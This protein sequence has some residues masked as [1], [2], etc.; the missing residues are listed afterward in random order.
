MLTLISC[1]DAF[2]NHKAIDSLHISCVNE[3]L[4]NSAIPL[5]TS[6]FYQPEHRWVWVAQGY[7]LSLLGVYYHLRGF[8][9]TKQV[10]SGAVGGQLLIETSF[11]CSYQTPI[12]LIDLHV[13]PPAPRSVK[14]A[15]ALSAVK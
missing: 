7:R 10:L 5:I 8:Y 13:A 2:D 6:L 3:L 15:E 12:L 1:C 4:S 14:A 11:R 9:R